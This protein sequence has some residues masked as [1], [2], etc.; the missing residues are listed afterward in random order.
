M[1][2]KLISENIEFMI[3]YIICMINRQNMVTNPNQEYRRFNLNITIGAQ[4]VPN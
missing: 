3:I 2:I 4:P 1:S